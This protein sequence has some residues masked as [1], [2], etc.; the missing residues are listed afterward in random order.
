MA[1]R[2]SADYRGSRFQPDILPI[3]PPSGVLSAK[4][5]VGAADRGKV[6]GLWDGETWT[7]FPRWTHHRASPSDLTRW[8]SWGGGIGLQAR[9]HPGVDIDVND[10]ALAD[11]IEALADLI[12]GPAPARCREGSSR[13]LLVYTNADH[14][15]PARKK[16]LAFTLP[17]SG[18]AEPHAVEILGLGQQY[19]LHGQHESGSSYLWRDGRDL[20]TPGLT[21]SPVNAGQLK[22]FLAA[23]AT[24]VR[25]RKGEIISRIDVGAAGKGGKR[26]PIG[27]PLLIARDLLTLHDALQA[28][29]VTELDY[30][31]WVAITAAYKAACASSEPFFHDS[32]LP[33]ALGYGGNDEEVCRAKWDSIQDAALGADWIYRVA[34]KAGWA[35]AEEF[36][37]IPEEVISP[38]QRREAVPDVTPETF[39]DRYAYLTL[40]DRYVDLAHPET[41][42]KGPQLS[43]ILAQHVG[44]VSSST[45]NA[46][47]L[48]QKNPRGRKYAQRTYRPGQERLVHEPRYGTCVN[49]WSP[50][51]LALPAH[52]TTAD[53][54]PWLD[55]VEYLLPDP[56]ERSILLDWFAYKIQSPGRKA[57]W[58]VL[59]GGDPGIGKDL[60]LIPILEIIGEANRRRVSQNTIESSF[61]S[62]AAE[63]ELVVIDE[64]RHFTP[65]TLNRL[66]A[67][68]TI[69]PDEVEISE[70]FQPTFSVPNVAAYFAFSNYRDALELEANDRRWFVLWSTATPQAAPYYWKLERWVRKNAGLLGRW[71]MERDVSK[72]AAQ[73]HAPSTRAKA[74][75]QRVT[76]A[77]FEAWVCES[78]ED[79]V[80]PFDVDLVILEDV[81]ARLPAHVRGLAPTM[82]KLAAALRQAG[83][84]PWPRLRLGRRLE[85]TRSDR[86]AIWA[87]RRPTMYAALTDGN[88]AEIYWRQRDEAAA[89][90]MGFPTEAKTA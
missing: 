58:A 26:L 4:S 77:P 25:D 40:L 50:P 54:R 57:N 9:D 55:H 71:L 64:V 15:E 28:I 18:A 88:L 82:L 49:S 72:F 8:D 39:L 11:E 48:L 37:P 69:P 12:L 83:G 14:R 73:G 63:T 16:R 52:A 6:P 23:V 38:G 31:E 46:A 43:N 45:Q 89:R 41:L 84:K 47:V 30:D 85:T 44:D 35:G 65:K 87:V 56:T 78:V 42:L 32:Y 79:G 51:P 68:I 10:A 33:W 17:A 20:L 59:L 61:S 5:A 24:L 80:V 86:A 70:K 66:K 21:V 36:D 1:P 74:E 60:M 2:R 53:V 22:E 76:Q 19:L 3:I 90:S 62:W 75:M 27:D 29:P 67:Y 34:R 81:M 7:G 13:R